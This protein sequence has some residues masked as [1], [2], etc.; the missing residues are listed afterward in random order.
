MVFPSLLAAVIAGSLGLLERGLPPPAVSGIVLMAG[1]LV[2]LALERLAP[3]HRAWNRRPEGLDLLLIV[4]NRVVDVA[5][6]A[7]ALALVGWLRRA[8]GPPPL[9]SL[10][11]A[12]APL[13][14]QAALGAVLA[15][16]GRYTLHRLS[17]RPGWLWR[18]H[19][20]HHQPRRMYSLNGPRLHPGNQLWLALANAVPMLL[21]GAPL[22]AVI[23]MANITVFFVLFQHAN[24]RLRF[25]G[26]NLLLA[27]PD[28]HRLHHR[29]GAARE[30]NLGIVLLVFDRLFGTYERTRDEPGPDDIGLR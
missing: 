18:I 13:L 11:P 23:L 21:L 24:V 27:T 14:A 12:E 2:V 4:V 20:T 28:V 9:L 10:W 29:R 17:H 8:G 7:G 1:V 22:S 3:L 25:D 19:R 26:W 16:A 30:V 15:E 6:V 5:V